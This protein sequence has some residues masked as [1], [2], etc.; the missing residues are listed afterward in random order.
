[1]RTLTFSLAILAA[2]AVTVN[3]DVIDVA[4]VNYVGTATEQAGLFLDDENRIIDGSG[5]SATLLADESNLATVSHAAVQLGAPGNAWA[6]I[7]AG[8]A[9]GDWFIDGDGSVIF[10][11]DLGGTFDVDQIAVWG[12]H[13]G[14]ANGNAVSQVRLDFSTDGGTTTDSSQTVSVPL[15]GTIDLATIIG[16]TPTSAN[17]ITMEVLDN[18]FEA[19]DGG[20]RVGIAEVAFTGTVS[21]VPEPSSALVLLVSSLMLAGRRR[22]S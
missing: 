11:F 6:T 22:K 1:M 7:D 21:A 5:L 13:F 2:I 20:D 3:A 14:A 10:D 15:P 17:F 19:A 16:L 9:G 8:L 4:S 12:Y 18:H